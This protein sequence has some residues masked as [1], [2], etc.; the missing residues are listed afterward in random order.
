MLRVI[1][2]ET[3][4]YKRVCTL[5]KS[6]LFLQIMMNRRIVCY[7]KDEEKWIDSLTQMTKKTGCLKTTFAAETVIRVGFWTFQLYENFTQD[8]NYYK[9]IKVKKCSKFVNIHKELY[10]LNIV[11]SSKCSFAIYLSITVSCGDLRQIGHYT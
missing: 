3:G 1:H 11:N 10:Y 2:G 5:L 7:T 9:L 4:N 8:N 6:E